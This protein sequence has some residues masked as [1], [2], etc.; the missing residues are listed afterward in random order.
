MLRVMWKK[1][2]QY[3]CFMLF[4]P[5][6]RLKNKANRVEEEKQGKKERNKLTKKTKKSKSG[7]ETYA[8][9]KFAERSIFRARRCKYKTWP[10][11]QT[12]QSQSSSPQLRPIEKPHPAKNL[13]C[14]CA[15]MLS[16]FASVCLL[17]CVNHD[18]FVFAFQ[19]MSP[20]DLHFS[21]SRNP[22]RNLT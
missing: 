8:V 12:R 22:T 14:L 13:C 6:R 7:R 10:L 5:R 1:N 15:C 2:M 19:D 17:M 18:L 20:S 21:L 9:T 4:T 11:L 3:L 16:A